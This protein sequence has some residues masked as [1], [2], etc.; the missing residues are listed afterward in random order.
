MAFSDENPDL[1]AQIVAA[2]I[3][4]E[5]VIEALLYLAKAIEDGEV[6]GVAE[7]AHKILTEQL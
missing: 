2:T 4:R 3:P 6:S 5:R 7:H 1:A